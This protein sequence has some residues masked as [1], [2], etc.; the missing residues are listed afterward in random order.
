MLEEALY[1]LSNFQ[2]KTFATLKPKKSQI[3]ERNARRLFMR[4][5]NILPTINNLFY[6]VESGKGIGNHA[7]I[8]I[9]GTCTKEEFATAIK[10][11][12]KR[13]LTYWENINDQSATIV[14]SSKGLKKESY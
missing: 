3:D 7:H 5:L 11:S 8:L 12:S 10:R 6:T 2:F 4:A 1:W 13:E 14:Y 9:D